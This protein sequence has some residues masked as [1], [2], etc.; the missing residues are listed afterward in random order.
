MGL[1]L[2]IVGTSLYKTVCTNLVG[3]ISEE[4]KNK[5]TAYT[6]FYTALNIGAIIAPVLYGTL[7]IFSWR[8]CFLVSSI[9]IFFCVVLFVVC[10]KSIKAFDNIRKTNHKRVKFISSILLLI[11][12]STLSFSFAKEI[13]DYIV[14]V[15]V[16]MGVLYLS[17]ILKVS[18]IEAR[19]IIGIVILLFFCI[20]FFFIFIPKR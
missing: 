8:S 4:S 20:F 17:P 15:L 9:G 5:N 19:R 10:S 18:K 13:N 7:A 6:V 2:T 1:S 16:V 11:F 3:V 12:I 14:V